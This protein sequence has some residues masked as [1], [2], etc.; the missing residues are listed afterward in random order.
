M[1]WN[2]N[3]LCG[4]FLVEQ[5][6]CTKWALFLSCQGKK[7]TM[8]S[9]LS[10]LLGN[11]NSVSWLNPIIHLGMLIQLPLHFFQVV[12]NGLMFLDYPVLYDLI[13]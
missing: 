12:A 10:L 13:L 11:L 4:K 2:I 1:R 5:N 9:F 7:K 6:L 8:F 3:R